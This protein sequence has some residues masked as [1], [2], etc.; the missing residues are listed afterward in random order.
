[1]LVTE[2]KPYLTAII[3]IL[4]QSQHSLEHIAVDSIL[5]ATPPQPVLH[6]K[7]TF[8][9]FNDLVQFEG[10]L[11]GQYCHAVDD[12]LELAANIV[13]YDMVRIQTQNGALLKPSSLSLSTINLRVV[14]EHLSDQRI[15]TEDYVDNACQCNLAESRDVA[16]N[17]EILVRFIH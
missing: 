9:N 11:G 3:F 15:V 4:W 8:I 12:Y 17:E 2:N 5:H 1:M 14:Y 6:N 10:Q 16:S 7:A 13:V